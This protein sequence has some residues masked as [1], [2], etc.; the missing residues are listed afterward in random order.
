MPKKP[1]KRPGGPTN[2]PGT[3]P[4]APDTPAIPPDDPRKGYGALGAFCGRHAPYGHA[5]LPD[6][7][8]DIPSYHHTTPNK[9]VLRF[10]LGDIA[11]DAELLAK[12]DP[13]MGDE[14]ADKRVVAIYPEP[15]TYVAFNADNQPP[16]AWRSPNALMPHDRSGW[17][18]WHERAP[19]SLAPKPSRLWMPRSSSSSWRA[20]RTNASW[21][22]AG[23][24]R[25]PCDSGPWLNPQAVVG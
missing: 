12:L 19:S 23:R 17:R 2:V 3:P 1:A 8:P 22:G 14:F 10:G 13:H 5:D 15:P 20:P 7:A 9:E 16:P 24:A 4:S 18:I 25:S 21:P 11:G 6:G